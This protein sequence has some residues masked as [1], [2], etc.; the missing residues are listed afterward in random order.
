MRAT[1]G[2]VHAAQG[3]G[4]NDSCFGTDDDKSLT[5]SANALGN[6]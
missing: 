1:K 3:E 2:S 4:R 5:L 6:T